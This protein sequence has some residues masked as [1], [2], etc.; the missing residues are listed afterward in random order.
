MPNV[1][2]HGLEVLKKA[3]IN[4]DP[5]SKRD[6]A[7]QVVVK[8]DPNGGN[9][10]LT[11]E[12]TAVTVPANTWVTVPLVQ[13]NNIATVETFDALDVTK[14]LIEWRIVGGVTVQIKSASANTYTIHTIGYIN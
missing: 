10:L 14:V 3:A 7:L 11:T 9:G 5:T 1:D 4:L 12:K 2:D 13:V 8:P 6:Y